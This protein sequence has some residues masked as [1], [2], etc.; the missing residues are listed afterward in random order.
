MPENYQNE[1]PAGVGGSRLLAKVCDSV[2]RWSVL[3]MAF[4]IPIL[5]LPWTMEAADFNK[6]MLLFFG[7]SIATLAWIGKMLAE[8]RFEYRRSVVNVA[9]LAFLVLYSLS[10]WLSVNPYLSLTG[11]FG[12][13]RDGL[14]TVIALALLYFVMVNSIQ[15]ESNLRRVLM[16]VVMGGLLA[17]LFGL[18]QGLGVFIL[19]FDFA[20]SASFN[21]VGTSS[22]LGILAAFLVLLCSGMLLYG[23][24]RPQKPG[25][26]ALL[27]KAL[28]VLTG[29]VS[30]WL[31]AAIDFWPITVAMLVTSLLLIGYS[32]MHAGSL[33]GMRG[34]ALPAASVVVALLVLFF[35]WSLLVR[36]PAE[37]MPSNRMSLNIAGQTLREYPFFGSGPGTYIFDYAKHRSV[38]IN[39]TSFWSVRFDRASSNF[40]SMLPSIGL[41]GTLT[42]L[43][44]VLLLLGSA[45]R[46]LLKADESTWHV[47]IG[48]FSAWFLLS[49]SKFL[50]SSSFTLEFLFWVMVALLVVV[51]RHDFYSVRFEKSPRASML[52]SFAFILGLVFVLSGAFVQVQRYYGEVAFRQASE[53]SRALDYDRAIDRLETA[54]SLNKYN[55]VYQRNL[56]LNLIAKTE[57]LVA[58]PPVMVR[59]SGESEDAFKARRATA[60]QDHAKLTASLAAEG[61]QAGRKATELGPSNVAN[62]SVLGSIYRK[63]IGYTEGADSWALASYTRAAELE[64]ANPVLPTEM[65]KMYLLQADL[66][67]NQASSA[68]EAA[69]EE[70][71][72]RISDLLS[73]AVES[74]EL[75]IKLKPDYGPAHYNLALTLERQNKLKEAISRMEMVAKDNPQDVGVGFQL[76]LL[77]YRNE[78]KELALN[79]M[80]AVVR[81]SPNFANARWYLAVMYEDMGQI[82]K[83]IAEIEKVKAMN[84]GNQQV[85]KKLSDLRSKLADGET[86]STVGELPPPVE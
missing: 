47:L 29:I 3:V 41:L 20:G 86:G 31:V 69:D 21:T 82:D 5:V 24:G 61:V 28:L 50:Y 12:Q 13:G 64:P 39:N 1:R 2:T 84:P 70:T 11:N 67:R 25:I 59:Q 44:L 17:V 26:W 80:E 75:G 53:A 63:L 49:L 30:L 23:H 38:E 42:W 72:G 36:F 27:G 57:K 32:F 83:A 46:T 9:V 16:S 51:H 33:R 77:Y 34:I 58:E 52:V 22:A 14:M 76:A 15:T 10:T 68:G 54:I 7:V 48:V 35:N 71:E 65:G 6:Q 19:P 60:Q 73:K 55:D 40:L 37:V 18:L 56:A 8:R 85:E 79:I 62:W 45:A 78:Q 81:L 66:I 43:A 4:L 74:F